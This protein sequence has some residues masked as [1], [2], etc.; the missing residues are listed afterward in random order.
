MTQEGWI[1]GTEIQLG[2]V[3]PNALHHSWVTIV[4]NLLYVYEELEERS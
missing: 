2:G 4:H 3:S 1:K